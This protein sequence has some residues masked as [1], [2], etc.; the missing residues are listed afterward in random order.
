MIDDAMGI[1]ARNANRAR[2]GIV[3]IAESAASESVR[4]SACRTILSVGRRARRLEALERRL[5][6][7]EEQW[8]KQTGI[9]AP[10]A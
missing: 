2:R 10:S 8:Q 9:E 4:L 5:A 7:I 3:A 6:R 1:L